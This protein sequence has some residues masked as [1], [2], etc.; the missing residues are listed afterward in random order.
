MHSFISCITCGISTGRSFNRTTG[1]N[2]RHSYI[3]QPALT[4]I[5]LS[6]IELALKPFSTASI[7]IHLK[8]KVSHF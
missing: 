7:S 5:L 4:Q 6:T 2:P 8:V 3:P 1:T